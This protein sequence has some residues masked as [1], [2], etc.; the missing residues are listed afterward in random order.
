MVFLPPHFPRIPMS[1]NVPLYMPPI[2]SDLTVKITP[3]CL[4]SQPSA[5]ILQS[6]FQN[7]NLIAVQWLHSAYKIKSKYFTETY[8]AF[9]NLAPVWFQPA[10]PSLSSLIMHFSLSSISTHPALKP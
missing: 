10:S 5:T 3:N 9:P 7:E 6:P 8:K 2:I 4:Q 1:P